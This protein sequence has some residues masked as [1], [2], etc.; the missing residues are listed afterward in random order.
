MP[1]P[2]ITGPSGR[3][4]PVASIAGIDTALTQLAAELRTPTLGP[5]RRRALQRDA[6]QL[7]DARK[8]LQTV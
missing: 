8:R 1:Q 5:V 6:D 4:Y 7:L 2:H 3:R